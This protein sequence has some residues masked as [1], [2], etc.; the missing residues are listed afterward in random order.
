MQMIYRDNMTAAE[1]A[2]LLAEC[3]AL[4]AMYA[5]AHAKYLASLAGSDAPSDEEIDAEYEQSMDH[6]NK[7][8]GDR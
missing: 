8:A 1:K 2:Q 7:I 5:D 3:D 4:D 6:L